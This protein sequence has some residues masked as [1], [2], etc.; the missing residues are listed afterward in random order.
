LEKSCTVENIHD[1]FRGAT[2]T[3]EKWR[4]DVF[5]SHRLQRRLLS[6][7]FLI[8]IPLDVDPRAMY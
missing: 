7:R 5:W 1:L 6:R 4:H 8:P 3:E 2:S